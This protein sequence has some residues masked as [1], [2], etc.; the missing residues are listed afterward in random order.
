[1]IFNSVLEQFADWGVFSQSLTKHFYHW[2]LNLDVVIDYFDND[3]KYPAHM[4]RKREDLK[5]L[6]EEIGYRDVEFSSKYSTRESRI[7]ALMNQ[8]AHTYTKESYRM[9]YP[10]ILEAIKKYEDFAIYRGAFFD[11][12]R[13]LPLLTS[14][15]RL[16]L[17]YEKDNWELIQDLYHSEHVIL[18]RY[19]SLWKNYTFRDQLAVLIE[20]A[21]EYTNSAWKVSAFPLWKRLPIPNNVEELEREMKL[22]F[23]YPIVTT[24]ELDEIGVPLSDS[25]RV[26]FALEEV[27]RDLREDFKKL[28]RF[29]GS[30][31][32]IRDLWQ[33][34]VLGPLYTVQAKA[35]VPFPTE[36]IRA[37]DPGLTYNFKYLIKCE[38][39]KK[40]F[41]HH[42]NYKIDDLGTLHLAA[43]V[44][45][46][47][48]EDIITRLEE[49]LDDY[50]L[51]LHMHFLGLWI[52]WKQDPEKL[53]FVVNQTTIYL[54]L[55]FFLG[56]FFFFTRKV[57]NS[58]WWK[59]NVK[60]VSFLF[61]LTKEQAN[62]RAIIHLPLLLTVFLFILIHN[63]IGLFPFGY[64]I[65]S[66]LFFT[67]FLGFSLLI[68]I[69]ILIWEE[70]KK[71]MINLFL[72]KGV[73]SFLVP[74]L[75][76]IELISYIFRTVS[77]SVRLFANMMAGHALLHILSNFGV[78]IFSISNP[79]RFFFIF[80]LIVVA[81]ITFLELGIALLQAYVFTVLLAIYFNDV[82]S[83]ESH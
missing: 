25:E 10:K 17:M 3:T 73:P 47:I 76:V 65:T 59:G 13:I 54:F 69:T 32:I 42:L 61:N 16:I 60:I 77:L 52:K 39:L 56:L 45:Q 4:E 72:P 34:R 37:E 68:G 43:F 12:E 8:N 44:H 35:L 40:R 78:V 5:I 50:Y 18:F 75:F 79:L 21:S 1:M 57:L 80:P 67:F 20:N 82:Y 29:S 64:T 2:N 70:K 63:L 74:F 31:E 27:R 49:H 7:E 14:P 9:L 81:L 19:P 41:F 55:S 51:S 23:N 6:L 58:G 46:S 66:H 24:S 38:L 28:H 30:E 62:I 33:L 26:A 36:A 53:I 48:R 83:L 71:E 11:C 15:M 22:T